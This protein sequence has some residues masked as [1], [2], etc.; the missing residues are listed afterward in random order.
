MMQTILISG[1][2]IGFTTSEH[3]KKIGLGMGGGGNVF[4]RYFNLTLT[5]THFNFVTKTKL[6]N[7]SF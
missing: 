1:C 2:N 3:I 6:E 5:K 4:A 7:R